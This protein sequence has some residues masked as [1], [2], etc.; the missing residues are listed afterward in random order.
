MSDP[1]DMVELPVVANDPKWTNYVTG[2]RLGNSLAETWGIRPKL[3]FTDSG[4]SC[5]FMDSTTFDFFIEELS[6]H[7]PSGISEPDGS[8]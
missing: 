1:E 6:R 4:T 8:G 7:A 3:A 2:F 5:L